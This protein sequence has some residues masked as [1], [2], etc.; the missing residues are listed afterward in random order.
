MLCETLYRSTCRNELN[1]QPRRSR[2]PIPSLSEGCQSTCGQRRQNRSTHFKSPQGL[3]RPRHSISSTP[4]RKCRP[5]AAANPEGDSDAHFWLWQFSQ[6]ERFRRQLRHG[7]RHT[8]RDIRS[9]CIDL[10]RQSL[11]CRRDRAAVRR[12]S[13]CSYTSLPQCNASASGRSAQC[14]VN[15]YWANAYQ[16]RPIRRRGVY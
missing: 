15:P 12:L 7:P 3:R 9:A 16:D 5:I 4:R 13:E 10:H 6:S 11:F 8:A 2:Q 14:V 1:P